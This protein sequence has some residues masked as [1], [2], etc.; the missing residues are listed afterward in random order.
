M[1]NRGSVLLA[2]IVI[3]VILAGGCTLPAP[4]SPVPV[5]TTP[6]QQASSPAVPGAFMIRAASLTP[7]SVLPDV[8]TCKGASESPELAWGGVPSGTKSLALIL[9]DPDSPEGRFTHWIVFNIPPDSRGL[10]RAQPNAKVLANG[11]QQGENSAGSRG[12]YPPCPPIGTSH[13]YVFRLYAVD[14]DITQ[15]TAD[16]DSI[17]WALTGHTI[18]KTEFT[19]TFR[20]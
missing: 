14:M 3:V 11:A 16:R 12:Y 6:A 13:R 8:Y 5:S 2:A 10:P 20:R 7:G 1:H 9:D 19:T 4:S 17:D 18:A 15:P